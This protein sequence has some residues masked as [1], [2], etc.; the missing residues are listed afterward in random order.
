MWKYISNGVKYTIHKQ[1]QKTQK[2]ELK[3]LN[4]TYLNRNTNSAPSSRQHMEHYT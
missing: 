4:I 3:I 2:N 1:Q